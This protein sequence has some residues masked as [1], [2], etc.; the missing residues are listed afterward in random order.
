M[1]AEAL[2]HFLNV[3]VHLIKKNDY[4][5]LQGYIKEIYLDSIL[6]IS[7]GRERLISFDEIA[8]IRELGRSPVR[9]P[10]KNFYYTGNGKE[11]WKR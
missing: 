3:T 8:E 9:P 6:F 1:D 10:T 11:S 4:T 2:K 7:Q 5:V